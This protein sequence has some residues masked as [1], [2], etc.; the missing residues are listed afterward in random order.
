[1]IDITY[2]ARILLPATKIAELCCE[3]GNQEHVQDLT[4]YVL[5][6]LMPS[7]DMHLEDH[8]HIFV[9][10]TFDGVGDKRAGPRPIINKDPADGHEGLVE[11]GDNLHDRHPGCDAIVGRQ[12]V[13]LGTGRLL[14]DNGA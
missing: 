6:R 13:A 14:D 5:E 11:F 1:M 3:L 9:T 8:A 7:A 2:I 12:E 4:G 10:L